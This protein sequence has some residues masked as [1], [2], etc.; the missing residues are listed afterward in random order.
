MDHL[1]STAKP[2]RDI[3]LG[4]AERFRRNAEAALDRE[5]ISEEYFTSHLYLQSNDTS[6]NSELNESKNENTAMSSRSSFI[7]KDIVNRMNR[8][9]ALWS[10]KKKELVNLL[11][12]FDFKKIRSRRVSDT[13]YEVFDIILNF[14]VLEYEHDI[15][16]NISDLVST[17]N[18]YPEEI[19]FYIPQLVIYLLYGSFNDGNQLTSAILV[20][21]QQQLSF[22]YRMTWFL[23][24]FCL[25]GAGIGTE[26]LYAIRGLLTQIE[27]SG[28]IATER[29][30]HDVGDLKNINEDDHYSNSS[31]TRISVAGRNFTSNKDTRDKANSDKSDESTQ[32][33]NSEEILVDY[34]SMNNMCST[35][36]SDCKLNSNE[37]YYP[38][39]LTKKTNDNIENYNLCIEFWD[40]LVNTARCLCLTERNE[41]KA[42][43]PSLLADI[44]KRYLPSSSIHIPVIE[45]SYHRIWAIHIEESTVFNTRERAPVLCCLEVV[46]YRKVNKRRKRSSWWQPI[47]S[48]LTTIISGEEGKGSIRKSAEKQSDDLVGNKDSS[49]SLAELEL[50]NDFTKGEKVANNLRVNDESIGLLDDTQANYDEVSSIIVH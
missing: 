4:M 25:S 36:N 12:T 38:L 34:K 26:G 46:F 15:A 7:F 41:R 19:E 39:H 50:K 11:K 14:F 6:N 44:N 13:S 24:S 10:R 23:K 33:L 28:A 27:R 42:K 22:C 31:A 3:A 40:S 30:N 29:L 9:K 20:M 21:C 18:E 5:M 16:V 8:A 43:L 35:S 45:N 37:A 2:V 1:R 47:D 49:A 17:F 32:L 48:F